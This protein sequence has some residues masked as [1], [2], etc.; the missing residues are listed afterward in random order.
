MSI[1]DVHR[2]DL[3]CWYLLSGWLLLMFVTRLMSQRRL[4]CGSI[5]HSKWMK[6]RHWISWKW[7][8][9]LSL[10]SSVKSR[11]FI[12]DLIPSRHVR[13]VSHAGTSVRNR[14][15]HVWCQ[16]YLLKSSVETKHVPEV[17]CAAQN[18]SSV[19]AVP[20]VQCADQTCS[21]SRYPWSQCTAKWLELSPTISG[22][23]LDLSLK[24]CQN[25]THQTFELYQGWMLGV[26]VLAFV[27]A[28]NLWH[29]E[30]YLKPYVRR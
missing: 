3:L 7:T 6:R 11:Q 14:R 13:Q 4:S 22:L 25:K 20:E 5:K 18:M 16:G 30:L 12:H 21:V 10:K 9:E 29:Q 27:S 24:P 19:N 28:Q 8:L 23:L 1:V 26:N 2:T 17:Q 15:D